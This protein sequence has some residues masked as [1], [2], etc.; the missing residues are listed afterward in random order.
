[1]S[2][3]LPVYCGFASTSAVAFTCPPARASSSSYVRSIAAVPQMNYCK[4]RTETPVVQEILV[5]SVK[6]GRR[7]DK[8]WLDAASGLAGG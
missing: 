4:P 7:V 6:D 1:M 5:N 3:L 8:S 2:W